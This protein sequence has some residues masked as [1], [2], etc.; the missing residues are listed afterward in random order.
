MKKRKFKQKN[1]R[2]IYLNKIKPTNG[3]FSVNTVKNGTAKVRMS[4][5]GNINTMPLHY[6]YAD[7][8]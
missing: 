8:S 3:M 7:L 4:Y 2:Q 6:S 5:M 1:L